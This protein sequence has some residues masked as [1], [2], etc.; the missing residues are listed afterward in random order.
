MCHSRAPDVAVQAVLSHV[1]VRTTRCKKYGHIRTYGQGLERLLGHMYG[2]GLCTWRGSGR[3]Q[4]RRVHREPTGLDRT[5]KTR[6]GEPQNRGNG[7]LFDRLQL[8]RGPVH[9]EGSGVPQYGGNG[10]LFECLRSKRGP[11]DREVCGIPQN[12]GN[13]LLLERLRSKQGPI[14]PPSTA[15]LQPP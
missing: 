10:P 15:S 14:H 8:K 6:S 2:Q 9:R 5:T 3:Q 7:L 12:G 4:R 1:H 13:R 11:V